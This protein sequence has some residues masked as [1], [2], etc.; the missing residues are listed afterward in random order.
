[1]VFKSPLSAPYSTKVTATRRPGAALVLLCRCGLPRTGACISNNL[2]VLRRTIIE[3]VVTCDFVAYQGTL[4]TVYVFIILGPATSDY[5]SHHQRFLDRRVGLT[6]I[7]RGAAGGPSQSIVIHDPDRITSSAPGQLLR[8]QLEDASR[9]DRS[10]LGTRA[11]QD[12][13]WTAIVRAWH[14]NASA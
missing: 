1:V 5:S 12:E 7:S 14:G 11:T 4:G 2:H 3:G 8:V 9:Q 6:A 10:L 13:L